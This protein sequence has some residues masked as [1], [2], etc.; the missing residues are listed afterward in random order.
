MLPTLSPNLFWRYIFQKPK[1][2]LVPKR[3][4]QTFLLSCA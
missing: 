1:H 4:F 3:I 2:T